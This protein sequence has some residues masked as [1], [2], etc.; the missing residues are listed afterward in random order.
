LKD[1]CVKKIKRILF[2]FLWLSSRIENERGIDGIKR[3]I[4][5]NTFVEGGLNISHVECL[6]KSIK[7]RK[8]VRANKICHPVRLTQRY[9]V[10]QIGFMSVIQQ[11]YGRITN[12]EEVTRIA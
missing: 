12:K 6:N 9:C 7:L 2:G 4:L 1:E 5:T 3:S 11:E 8:F 10:E